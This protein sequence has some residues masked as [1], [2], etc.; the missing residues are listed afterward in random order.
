M[1]VP[2]SFATALLMTIL[3][4]CCWGS[5]ANTFKLTKNYR[6]ELYYWD[7][8]L[9]IFLMSLIFA[10]TLGSSEGGPFSFV[11]NVRQAD[12]ILL[13]CAAL[14]GFVFNIA[15]VLLVAG[16]EM[17]GLAIAFPL[18]IGIALV[19]GTVLSYLTRPQGNAG[20][21]AA[22]VIMALVAVIFIGMAYAAR[23]IGG[24]AT[25]RKGTMVC[26]VSGL[27][28]G[29]FAP[30]ITKAMQGSHPDAS[31]VPAGALSPYTA[32]VFM[33]LGA[34]LCCFVFNPILMRRPLVGAPVSMSGYFAAPAGYHVL[35]LLGGA[36]WGTGTVLN[37]VAGR[38]VGVPI[39]Y[40]IGQASPMI[41]TLWGV[42]AWHEFRGAR[43]KSWVYLAA[44]FVSY[45]LALMLIALAFKAG[46][47]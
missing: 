9:G 44:M 24:T 18:S 39:S 16:I 12:S 42:F 7:F 8:G 28:M 13:F 40:A 22:G 21:L 2:A 43:K 36:I 30:A 47:A 6:F 14:G 5:F 41:A 26:V 17:V 3:C 34:F 31:M 4:T 38:F 35:G 46:K 1:F 29:V 37:F 10:F 15:N 25:S 27:L 11:P 19:E 20:L 45:L 23:G 32:A 33:T